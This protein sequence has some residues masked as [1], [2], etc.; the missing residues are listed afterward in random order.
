MAEFN[1]INTRGLDRDQLVAA[2]L[3][4]E[5]RAETGLFAGEFSLGLSSG[6]SGNKTLT[7]LD[8]TERARYGC[9]LFSRLTLPRHAPRRVLFALRTNNPA[10]L[11]VSVFGI[12]IVYTDYTPSLD[13]LLRT[14]ND[15]RLNILCGPPTLLSLLAEHRDEIRHS[16][17]TLFSYA[18]VLSAPHRARLQRAFCCPVNEIYQ[19]AE[20]FLAASCRAGRLHLNEDTVLIEAPAHPEAPGAPSNVIVTDLYRTTQPFIRYRMNDLLEFD[21]TPCPCGSSFRTIARIHGRRDDV[22]LL[23][24]NDGSTRHLFP[25]YVRRCIN[26][27]SPDIREFQAIQHAVDH[28]EI[29]LQ[30]SPGANLAAIQD[31]IVRNLERRAARL[32]AEPGSVTFSD[33]SPERNPRSR[34]LIR[35]R[36]AF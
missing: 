1:R 18:E 33:R 28:I 12:R 35:V 30:V 20:G 24:G 9:L 32:Q 8:R 29:R 19:G 4:Q 17:D 16:I 7:V 25:D 3:K 15:E 34:K 26:Q 13:T 27:A 21:R 23:R 6:T 10:Y 22:F 5:A 2:K 11:T 31:R 14:I 36:R